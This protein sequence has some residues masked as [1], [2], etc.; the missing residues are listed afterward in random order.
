[1]RMICLLLA[2]TL[3]LS[4]A[5]PLTPT[6]IA[7]PTPP[8][9]HLT[10]SGTGGPRYDMGHL[11][12]TDIYVSPTG[13][14][15]TGNGSFGNPYASLRVAYRSI[16]LNSANERNAAYR[17]RLMPGAYA[18]S[19]V[20]TPTGD[21]GQHG[22]ANTP[23]LIESY[24][25]HNRARI[26][27]AAPTLCETL[28]FYR[29]SYTYLQNID[30][31]VDTT[32]NGSASD[33]ESAGDVLQCEQCDHILLRN[34]LIRGIRRNA[35]TEGLKLNQSSHLYIEDS[36]I[37]GA[38]DNAIDTVAIL[39][40]WFVRNRVHDS[41]D[42]C[43]Y[44]KG[45]SADFLVAYNEF[46]DCGTGGFTAGQGSSFQFMTPPFIYHEAYNIKIINNLI[47]DV[48]GA[49]I[50][51]NGGFNIL[52]AYNTIHR[53][54]NDQRNHMAEFVPGRR[55]CDVGSET[56]CQTRLAAGGWGTADSS[57]EEQQYIPNRHIYV[58][59][60]IFYNPNNHLTPMNVL[61][62]R[63]PVPLPTG[64]TGPNP[65]YSDD[66]LVLR[67]NIFWTGAISDTMLGAGDVNQG[68]AA[69]NGTCNPTQLYADNAI[70]T[71]EPQIDTTAASSSYLQPI[72][73]SNIFSTTTYAVPDFGTIGLP[74]AIPPAIVSQV[75]GIAN[76]VTTDYNGIARFPSPPGAFA[77]PAP[78]LN[79][80][81][82]L[83]LTRK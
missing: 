62:V 16:P 50:G 73:G 74:A 60:N 68:C 43:A 56:A 29:A 52:I 54:G 80:T 70:N 42:W 65:A 40:G 69:N 37:S 9:Y 51:V 8:P 18:G 17:I 19:Y 59:N 33:P 61:Q 7:L 44:I 63:G 28:T 22:T 47:H 38:G 31:R 25:P 21:E 10:T 23:L 35:Q 41:V 30:V 27:C 77:G 79:N 12:Y 6:S 45:G 32:V 2:G 15:D 24:D 14:D 72:N 13:H 53:V 4:A 46:Y 55:V 67:G 5:T 36:D 39:H 58:Y 1:M 57:Q 3:L 49:G 76:A 75:N 34:L 83:P 48:Q 81:C 71:I 82:Y 66:D 26:L 78:I 20:D 11:T 64:Y